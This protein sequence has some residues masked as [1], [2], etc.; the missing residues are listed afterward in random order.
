MSNLPGFFSAKYRDLKGLTRTSVKV[1]C[2]G[3]PG[4]S[5]ALEPG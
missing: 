4:I 2:L 3:D 1:P 5:Q